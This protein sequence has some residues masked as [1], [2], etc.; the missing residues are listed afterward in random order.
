MKGK[1]IMITGASFGIGRTIATLL[2]TQGVK[3]I[4]YS[5]RENRLKELQVQLDTPSYLLVFDVGNRKTVFEKINSL[6]EAYSSIDIL[7]NNAGN[8]HGLNTVHKAD[9][10][11]LDAII[12]INVKGLIYVTKA[13]LPTM[14]SRK[15]GHIINISSI[16]EKEVYPTEVYT[17]VVNLRWMPL[18]KD[19]VWI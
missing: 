7:I 5:R 14:V 9:L 15:T 3:L 16:G 11:N 4:L 19:Y 1:N 2:A 10:K 18:P 8:T 17:V 12:D 13:V 6:Q